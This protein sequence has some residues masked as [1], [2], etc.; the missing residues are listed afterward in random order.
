MEKTDKAFHDWLVAHMPAFIKEATEEESR[1]VSHT[2]VYSEEFEE[3]VYLNFRNTSL[4]IS[5]NREHSDCEILRVR[6][7]FYWHL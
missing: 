6:S 4:V 3:Y 7:I 1:V 2:L 5:L